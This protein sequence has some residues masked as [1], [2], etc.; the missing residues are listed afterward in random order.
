MFYFG[1]DF[2]GFK[3]EK[4]IIRNG[5]ANQKDVGEATK[6]FKWQNEII[7]TKGKEPGLAAVVCCASGLKGPYQQN[8]VPF[9]NFAFININQVLHE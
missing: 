1:S 4:F 2:I 3:P 7:N 8:E 5:G 6:L 9:K